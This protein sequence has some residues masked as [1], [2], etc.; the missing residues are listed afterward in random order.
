[1]AKSENWKSFQK[2]VIVLATEILGNQ[3]KL[4]EKMGVHRQVISRW[5]LG[6]CQ[7]SVERLLE[8]EGIIDEQKK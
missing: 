4:A 8:L 1:M 6:T 5:K 7:M 2:S 3:N